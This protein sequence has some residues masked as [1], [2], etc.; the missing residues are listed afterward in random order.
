MGALKK[1]PLN[2]K[3]FRMN[4]LAIKH[5]DKVK[6][7]TPER[8]LD[9]PGMIDDFY[10]NLLDWGKHNVVAIALDNLA[11]CMDYSTKNIS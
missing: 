10:L 5:T 9:A 2:V 3:G 4:N 1:N 7:I 8:I 11:Y 6:R